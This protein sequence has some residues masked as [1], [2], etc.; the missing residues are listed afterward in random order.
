[1][2]FYVHRCSLHKCYVSTYMY[3]YFY[4]HNYFYLHTQ[5]PNLAASRLAG[6][7]VKEKPLRFQAPGSNTKSAVTVDQLVWYA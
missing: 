5:L 1:M 2:Y 6:Y 4:L 7:S 3:F